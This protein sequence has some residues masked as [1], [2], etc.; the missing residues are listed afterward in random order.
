M[1]NKKQ[2][3]WAVGVL[4][5]AYMNDELVRGK[6]QA[7]AVGNLVKSACNIPQNKFWFPAWR[8]IHGIVGHSQYF[9]EED[10]REGLIEI[11]ATGYTPKQTAK[12]EWAFELGGEN[13]FDGLMSVVD[14]LIEIHE[15]TEEEKLQTKSMFQKV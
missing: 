4:V 14:C 3:D 5:K 8:F 2:F 10:N 13:M 6:C 15:G 9:F 11:K 1:K 7:C 12:I